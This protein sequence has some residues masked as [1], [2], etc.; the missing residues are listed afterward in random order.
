MLVGAGDVGMCGVPEV[1]MTASLLEGIPGTIVALGD[2]AYP[3]GSANDFA[4]CYDPTW[5]RVRDAHAPRAG[6]P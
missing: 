5:G 1:A 6:Q 4:T 2:L 3:A